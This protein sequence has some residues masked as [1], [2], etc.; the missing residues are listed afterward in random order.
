MKKHDPASPDVRVQ[1]GQLA[2]RVSILEAAADVFCR[3]GFSGASIDEIAAEAGVSRQT[4]YNHYRE[5][6][7]LFMAVIQDIMDRTNGVLF[8]ILA[9]FPERADNLEEDLAA[10]A[11]RLNKNCICNQDA[12]F[13]QKLIATEGNRYPHLFQFWREQGPGK[14]D[15]ALAALFARLAHR[16][17]LDIDDFDLAARQFIALIKADL[18]MGGLF[19]EAPG[20][21]ELE[22]SA[23]KAVQTFLRAYGRPTGEQKT[24]KLEAQR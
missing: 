20:E 3:E 13:I 15:R 9:T 11:V 6:E 17:P 12:K 19:G 10:F 1:K 4:V 22:E 7:T 5:K 14:T 24:S 2:K 23:R 16:A 18:Q 21:A 8:S